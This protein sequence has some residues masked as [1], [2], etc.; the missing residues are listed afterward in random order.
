MT[1]R[2]ADTEVEMKKYKRR[3]SIT[4][5]CFLLCIS[6]IGCEGGQSRAAYTQAILREGEDAGEGYIDSFVF[7]GESTTYHLKS[8]G[9]LKGGTATTQV[10]SNKLGTINLD[11]GI[12]ALEVV[13][14]ETGEQI[15][16]SE[17]LSR[18]RPER[19]LLTFGLNGA[20][21][22]I[23]RGESYFKK[24]YLSLIEV[25]RT[26]SPDTEIILQSCFP[27][28][29]GMDMSA[30]SVDAATLCEYIETINSWTLS[31]A[32]SEGLRYLNT[33]EAL[34]DE[35]GFLKSEY[36]ADD[37]YHLN[38]D[39]YEAILLYIRTHPCKEDI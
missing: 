22:K 32:H 28:G 24:C 10:W 27:I 2:I 15:L 20:V 33:A 25:I 9:V 3:L 17:A 34:R 36:C 1:V 14:P 4:F 16:L 37:Y 11:P 12:S 13:Y 31:L 18:K 35:Q 23:K 7:L 29:K 5:F 30:Y 6:L 21:E 26:S 38:T 39:A 19:M 8:R